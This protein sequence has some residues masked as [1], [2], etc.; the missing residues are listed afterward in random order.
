[1]KKFIFIFFIL[2]FANAY[3]ETLKGG[4]CEEYIPNGF[5]GSWGVISKLQET[6]NPDLFNFQSKDIWTLSGYNNILI[7]DNLES[8]ATSQIEI[9]NKNSNNILKFERKKEKKRNNSKIIYKEIVQFKLN[10]NNFSG[11]DDFIVEEY[12]KN[13]NLIKQNKAKYHV[14]GVKISGNTPN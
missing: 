4:V 12:D 6:N 8:G 2:F 11:S 5:F 14:E 9:K 10:G 13:N 7:L 3:C 1:M